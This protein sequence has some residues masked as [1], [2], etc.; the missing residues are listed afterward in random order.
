[1]VTKKQECKR[2]YDFDPLLLKVINLLKDYKDDLREQAEIFLQNVEEKVSKE[3]IDRFY[4]LVK[5]IDGGNRWY[6]SDPVISK[7]IEL[8]RVVPVDVQKNVS[9][10]FI[11]ALKDNGVD[12]D[13]EK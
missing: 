2:W 5:P 3:A 9:I 10:M 1:M 7:T 4:N 6:D 13:A 12:V 8:L 11:E